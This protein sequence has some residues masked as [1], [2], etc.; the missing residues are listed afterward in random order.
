MNNGADVIS[1]SLGGM[2]L[3]ETDLP[4]TTAA[5]KAMDAGVVVCVASGNSG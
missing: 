4:V 2:D 1:M 5:D 3:G